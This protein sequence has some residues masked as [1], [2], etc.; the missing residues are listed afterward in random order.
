M[1]L[2]PKALTLK[3]KAWIT[4]CQKLFDEAPSRFEFL[5]IG[6][7]Y[8]DIIDGDLATEHDVAL[9]NGGGSSSGVLLE[10]ITL[11]GRMHGVAG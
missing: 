7:W 9:E 6:D 8:F 10:T 3:E 11:K 4:R 1:P 5:T 2:K